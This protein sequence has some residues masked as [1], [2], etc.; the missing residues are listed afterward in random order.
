MERKYLSYWII[1]SIG[2][3]L[4]IS[5]FGLSH[6]AFS[7]Q[8]S[9]VDEFLSGA[10]EVTRVKR[11]EQEK[12]FLADDPIKSSWIREVEVR[13]RAQHYDETIDDY[14]FRVSPTNPWE[15]R[16]NKSYQN[17]LKEV[18]EINYTLA[19]GKELKRRYLLLIN[20]FYQ[21]QRLQWL[22]KELELKSL[23]INNELTK[24]KNI[25]PIDLI[26]IESNVTELEVKKAN[27]IL[28]HQETNTPIQKES[29]GELNW[30]KWEMIAPE[31]ILQLVFS[32]DTGSLQNIHKA[33]ADSKLDL[34]RREYQVSKSESFG[35]IGFIQANMDLD[36][37]STF[38]DH[39]GFQLGVSIPIV[40]KK[41]ADLARD[42]FDLIESENDVTQ[43][44]EEVDFELESIRTRINSHYQLFEL[45]Q[46]KMIR[47]EVILERIKQNPSPEG[48][49]KFE[50]YKIELSN[51]K[52]STYNELLISFIEFLD[53][54]GALAYDREQNYL[55]PNLSS[56]Y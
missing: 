20:S 28:E 44:Y 48:I 40:N 56:I 52:I 21:Y 14:R 41:K 19:I 7:Q 17:Q 26:D 1:K 9:F 53:V 29:T 36:Q 31:K 46:D 3:S 51:Q 54:S 37:G 18:S 45:I 49:L 50:Q 22:D 25:D 13:A 43:T 6:I 11:F 47:S 34:K 32:Q 16:A 8:S 5:C 10:F 30:D 4:A 42:R 2:L 24:S 39:M 55:S 23:S 33:L 38:N 15:I 35:N 27:L 12:T